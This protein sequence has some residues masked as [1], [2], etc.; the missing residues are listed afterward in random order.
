MQSAHF[1]RLP[2]IIPTGKSLNSRI[3]VKS[4]IDQKNF[5]FGMVIAWIISIAQKLATYLEEFDFY[6]PISQ[7]VYTSASSQ[8]ACLHGG[9]QIAWTRC[10]ILCRILQTIPLRIP[11]NHKITILWGLVYSWFL[12]TIL[13]H[14][15]ADH[16]HQHC[17]YPV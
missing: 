4:V 10:G 3:F 16:A 12:V 11:F 6:V 15:L 2:Y 14:F 8:A 13:S 1:C 7:R 17:K 5:K 9:S